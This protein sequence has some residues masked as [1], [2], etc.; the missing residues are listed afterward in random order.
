MNFGRTLAIELMDRKLTKTAFAEMV[1]VSPAMISKICRRERMPSF[2][3]AV[4]IAD[5][6]GVTVDYLMRG[7][8]TSSATRKSRVSRHN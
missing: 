3:V 5:A 7:E 1:G 2:E 6:L 4:K 8:A